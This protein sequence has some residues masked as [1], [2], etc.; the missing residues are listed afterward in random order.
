MPNVFITYSIILL[1]YSVFFFFAHL[2]QKENSGDLKTIL[3]GK[4][5]PGILLSRLIAGILLLGIGITGIFLSRSFNERIVIP[6][7]SG[8]ALPGWMLI[9]AAGLIGLLGAEKKLAPSIINIKLLSFSFP[10]LFILLR[11]LFL[12][13]YEIF[14]RGV[15]L[16]CMIEDF[17]IVIAVFINLFLYV[18]IHWHSEKKERYGSV[19]MGLVLCLISIYYQNVW[20]AIA[21]HLMLALSNE[22]GILI[23]NR[24]LIKTLRL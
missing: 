5:S 3:S 8:S 19:L 9:T 16:F 11:T 15:M 10:L 13:V 7:V 22:I 12:I 14:F 4:G 23:T 24:S 20:P 21:I 18:F 17:G 2:T 6:V 1:S